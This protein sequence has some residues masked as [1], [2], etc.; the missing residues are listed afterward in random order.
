MYQ[1]GVIYLLDKDE[2]DTIVASGLG[3]DAGVKNETQKDTGADS[4]DSEPGRGERSSKN[5][6][7]RRKRSFE[8][9]N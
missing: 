4:K 3:W 9:A 8:S 2:A 1:P 5:R 6:R 7:H